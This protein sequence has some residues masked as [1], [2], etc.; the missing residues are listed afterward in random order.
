M[1]SILD[2]VGGLSLDDG[3]GSGLLGALQGVSSG[4]TSTPAGVGSILE[5]APQLSLPDTHA[6]LGDGPTRLAALAGGG[7]PSADGLWG[8]L[9]GGLAGIESAL[10][11]GLGGDMDAVFGRV[12]A[13]GAAVPTDPS[14]L[15]AQ[16]AEPLR[17][18]AGAL[19]ENPE[20]QHLTEALAKVEE[21]RAQ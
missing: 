14:A 18:A 16:L 3:V 9:T 4:G 21:I 6:L 19:T 7:L 5:L 1:G 2:S 12:S 10:G 13:L 20:L 8:S 15:L 17:S 11:S